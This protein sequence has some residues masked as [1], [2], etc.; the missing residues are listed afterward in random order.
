MTSTVQKYPGNNGESGPEVVIAT[1]RRA[2]V[3][4]S[5]SLK[6]AGLLGAKGIGKEASHAPNSS[7][8]DDATHPY[9]EKTQKRQKGREIKNETRRGRKRKEKKR[10][11]YTR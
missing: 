8:L 7:C 2:L 5:S 10:R 1:I 9:E 3:V 11:T 6:K 4:G